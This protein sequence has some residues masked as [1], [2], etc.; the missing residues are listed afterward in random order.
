MRIEDVDVVLWTDGALALEFKATQTTLPDGSIEARCT[1]YPAHA[2]Y[3]IQVMVW[4]KALK[5]KL[6]CRRIVDG[7][8]AGSTGYCLPVLPERSIFEYANINGQRRRL[9]FAPA[10]ADAPAD[11][12]PARR[13]Q[14]AG[15]AEIRVEIWEGRVRPRDEWGVTDKS[16]IFHPA[17]PTWDKQLV[18][19]AG[20]PGAARVVQTTAYG[21]VLGPARQVYSN[22]TERFRLLYTFVFD[23]RLPE[24]AVLGS[25]MPL[26]AADDAAEATTSLML[27][28]SSPVRVGS[29][30]LIHVEPPRRTNPA[31][32]AAAVISPSSPISPAR[33][34]RRTQTPQTATVESPDLFDSPGAF[35]SQ[36]ALPSSPLAAKSSAA[37]DLDADAAPVA[38]LVEPEPQPTAAAIAAAA[39]ASVAYLRNNKASASSASAGAAAKSSAPAAATS[40]SSSAAAAATASSSAPA[41]P[42]ARPR[43]PL[44]GPPFHMPVPTKGK[45]TAAP[46]RTTAA[47][48]TTKCEV[49]EISSSDEDRSPARPAPTPQ[50][51]ATGRAAVNKSPSPSAASKR[52]GNAASASRQSSITKY[53]SPKAKDGSSSG[54]SQSQQP[55]TSGTKRPASEVSRDRSNSAATAGASASSSSGSQRAPQ[56]PPKKH[57]SNDAPQPPPQPQRRGVTEVI[58]LCTSSDDE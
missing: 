26:P 49:I 50:R 46:A 6:L 35:A 21:R 22:K 37:V 31:P 20:A 51:A 48:S 27:P 3:A 12:A 1:L 39:A 30:D 42:P 36:H 58:D 8:K 11:A 15:L 29:E 55:N 34:K 44:P 43:S 18:A 57:R 23:Y 14:V 45:A 19:P 4:S 17:D 16:R 32:A 41:A 24:S 2:E 5:D 7:R 9:A 13:A 53:F 40:A 47:P 38:R 25:A 10:D 56:H 54:P 28:S 33:R 52:S